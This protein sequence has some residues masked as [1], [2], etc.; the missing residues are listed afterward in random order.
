MNRPLKPTGSTLTT[1]LLA[2]CMV[3]SAAAHVFAQA[4]LTML[5]EELPAAYAFTA[6]L[7]VT[8][9]AAFNV[10]V[11]F[12]QREDSSLA[13]TITA[14]KVALERLQAGK[15]TPIGVSHAPS[16]LE[17]GATLPLTIQRNG[18]RIAVVLGEQVVARAWDDSPAGGQAG[19]AVTGGSLESPFVQPLGE[20]YLSDDFVRPEEATSTWDPATG[21]W[22]TQ[23]LRVDEQADRMEADKSMNAFSYL[24]KSS[25][26]GPALAVAGYWFW[27]TY[28]VS[29]AVRA[30]G[31][32]AMG[33]V[34]YYQDP[35]NYLAARWTSALAQGE[36]ADSLALLQVVDGKTTVLAQV[37]GGH[38]PQ[39]WYQLELRIS[40]STV[41]CLIDDELR[42][43]A[44][45]DGFGQGQA[46]LYC[47]GN[48]GT[49]F[50]S[51]LVDRWE[52]FADDFSAPAPGKWVPVAGAWRTD[53]G[54]MIGTGDGERLCEAGGQWSRFIFS[55]DFQAD[56]R[57][58]VGLVAAANGGGEY[59]LRFG[60]GGTYDN[61]A[62][63]VLRRE[64]RIRELVS[65]PVSIKPKSWHRASVVV[66]DGLITAYLDGQRLFD[67]FDSQAATGH[68][69]FYADGSA[70]VRFDNAQLAM[71]PERRSTRLTQEFTESEE[72]P[73]M[74][75]WASTRAP[76]IKPADGAEQIWWTKGDYYGDK[77]LR[78]S[79][80]SVGST[81]GNVRL[82]IDSDPGD[83]SEGLTL[84]I[85][86]T[87]GSK[88]L[89]AR[90]YAGDKLLQEGTVETRS[91]PCRV[92]VERR[93]TYFVTVIDDKVVLSIEQ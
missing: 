6:D 85:E 54:E 2:L 28:S 31:Q 81:T 73:E 27:G 32:D 92:L 89:T 50:D 56:S 71:L 42:V 72:H 44:T 57:G 26:D 68:V 79:I 46:G 87:E 66:E 36:G 40:D 12:D 70:T 61:R 80:P 53:G 65:A 67:A 16:G 14:S 15:A 84:V 77:Q 60:V 49:N 55:A 86:A 45:T 22:Q 51:V 43:A 20:M 39:R 1:A 38:L 5:E 17:A 21:S 58:G 82:R 10:R 34:A 93:G 62:Q 9:P 30:A 37:P 69:G 78:F 88:T 90:V 47:E 18:W 41:Q 52:I 91:D 19:Y 23:S 35:G 8:D 83:V 4:D 11:V 74:V 3:G 76:W 59:M 75:E 63:V 33:L 24:G 13:L 7:Q 29:A 48:E 64:G 25:G